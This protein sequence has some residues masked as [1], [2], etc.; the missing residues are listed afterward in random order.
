M[1]DK[2][3]PI[4]D[5]LNAAHVLQDWK[6]AGKISSSVKVVLVTGD[7]SQAVKEL[8]CNLFDHVIVKPVERTA[9]ERIIR[10]A[11]LKRASSSGIAE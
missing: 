7:E 11:N 10:D 8:S 9:I 6:R 4:M 5:G 1:L 3:M 2:N